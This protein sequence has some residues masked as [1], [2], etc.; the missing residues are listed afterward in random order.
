DPAMDKMSLR[1]LGAVA[2]LTWLLVNDDLELGLES[3]FASGDEWESSKSGIINIHYANYLPQVATDT[4][5]TSFHFN[6]DYHVDRILFRELLGAVV[7]ATYFKPWIRYNITDRFWF[8]A[9]AIGS[10]ANV[11][12]ATPG[13]GTFY[14][15]ELNGDLGYNNEKEGFFAGF[16]YG[17][18]FPL[19]A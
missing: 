13:N 4:T 14:G 12:V 8:K 15:I 10:V 11:P 7:N 16:S 5:I 6:Y 3:G 18:L 17:V 9:A 19:G 1:E 2:R